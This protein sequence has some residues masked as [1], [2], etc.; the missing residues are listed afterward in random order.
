MVK[1]GFLAR[2]RIVREYIREDVIYFA[3]PGLIV[4][5]LGLIFSTKDGWDGIV[6]TLWNLIMQPQNLLMLSVQNIVGLVLIIAGFSIMLVGMGT[7]R[8]SHAST[9]VIRENH[10][11]R[12]HGIY[13]FIRHPMYLGAILVTIGVPVHASSL[14]GF[15]VML[16][17]IPVCLSRIRIEERMLTEEFGDE[18]RKYMKTTKKLFPFIY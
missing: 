18:Y 12:T 15:W 4:F 11:L 1:R 3:I 13:R 10:K 14:Y 7:L 17:L 9:L 16:L 6:V 5:T 8:M 2:H